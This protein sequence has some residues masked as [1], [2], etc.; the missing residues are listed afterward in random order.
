MTSW[1]WATLGIN[2]AGSFAAGFLVEWGFM[3][4][5]DA[6]N[7]AVTVGLLGGFTTYS[8]FAT[9][10]VLLAEEGRLGAA[11]AYTGASVLLGLCA[12]WLGVRTGAQV[13]P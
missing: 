2:V 5:S 8:A 13:G 10:S 11:F 12:A 1:P 3:R 4:L 6:V 7:T 9:Q